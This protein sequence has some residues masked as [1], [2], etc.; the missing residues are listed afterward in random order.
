M[1]LYPNIVP[2]HCVRVQKM[3]IKLWCSMVANI[4]LR[5][6][7]GLGRYPWLF[8]SKMKFILY[9]RAWNFCLFNKSTK[10]IVRVEFTLRWRS[11]CISRHDALYS[12]AHLYFR[13]SRSQ[14]LRL[15]KQSLEGWNSLTQI[16]VCIVLP[17]CPTLSSN[18]WRILFRSEASNSVSY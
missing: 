15:P 3:K 13:S 4:I 5:T 9:E 12:F 17:H 10:L 11:L 18:N 7:R 2:C 8:G 1:S 16:T 14:E 6:L